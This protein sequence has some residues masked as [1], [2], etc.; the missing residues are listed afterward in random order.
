M[1]DSQL[2]LR[3]TKD[4]L[5]LFISLQLKLWD[6]RTCLLEHTLV[7]HMQAVF[8]VDMDED[9]SMVISGSA[10]RVGLMTLTSYYSILQ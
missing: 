1:S 5:C 6:L 8:C 2:L 3:P 7:G 10:D 4:I 9:C